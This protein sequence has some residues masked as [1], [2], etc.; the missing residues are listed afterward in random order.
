MYEQPILAALRD[1]PLDSDDSG[2]QFHCNKVNHNDDGPEVATIITIRLT[3][4]L[5]RIA[6]ASSIGIRMM[7][8][9][10]VRRPLSARRTVPLLP[11]MMMRTV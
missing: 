9:E 11:S 1:A 6:T 10:T 7:P 3:A 4:S 8:T 2:R 5:R